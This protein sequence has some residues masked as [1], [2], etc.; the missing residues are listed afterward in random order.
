MSA[1]TESSGGYPLGWDHRPSR[2]A[3]ALKSSSA[4]LY[5][6]P[7]SNGVHSLRRAEPSPVIGYCGSPGRRDKEQL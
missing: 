5:T 6:F 2:P 4:E 7:R 3:Q 1:L